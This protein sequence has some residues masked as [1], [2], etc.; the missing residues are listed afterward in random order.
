MTALRLL[1]LKRVV[2]IYERPTSFRQSEEVTHKNATFLVIIMGNGGSILTQLPEGT[3]GIPCWGW[4][5]NTG[6]SRPQI[7]QLLV[8]EISSLEI[9][10]PLGLMSLY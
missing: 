2:L 3:E 6:V 8:L 9:L 7:F 1:V 10:I 4:I 5:R